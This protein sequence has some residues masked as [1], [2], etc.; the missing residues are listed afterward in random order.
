[1]AT[2]TGAVLLSVNGNGSRAGVINVPYGSSFPAPADG[3]LAC[4]AAARCVVVGRQSDGTA[5]LSVFALGAGGA[6]TDES[7]SGFPSA[8]SV[9]QAVDVDGDGV[10]EIAVQESDGSHTGWIV[11]AWSGD[12]FTI[13]GCAPAGGSAAVPAPGALSPDACLS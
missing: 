4:D 6:W 8:T 7:G 10:L 13:K 2:G 12:K 3:R 1:M 5:I 9:G 11:F